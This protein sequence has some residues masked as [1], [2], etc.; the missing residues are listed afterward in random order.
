LRK[1]KH[2]LVLCFALV[3]G[4]ILAS[5]DTTCL[6]DEG[7]KYG[8]ESDYFTSIS[9]WTVE[10]IEKGVSF[11][12]IE[13]TIF[14]DWTTTDTGWYKITVRE[15]NVFQ[16]S[17]T[18]TISCEGNLV[19]DSVYLVG[20][21]DMR[22]EP[23]VDIEI[24]FGDS[25]S[26]SSNYVYNSYLWHNGQSSQS[27]TEYSDGWVSLEVADKYG[28][29][30]SDSSY[31]TVHDLPQVNLGNDTILCENDILYY[32]FSSEGVY[33]DW[34][35][36]SEH[37][38]S[39]PYIEIDEGF[40]FLYNNDTLS[41]T[42]ENTYG[43]LSSD[44]VIYIPCQNVL[45]KIP[46]VI[47]PNGDGSNDYWVIDRLEK[48]PYNYPELVIEI[49]DRWGKLVW[50][51]DPGYVGNEFMGNDLKGRELPS[52]SYFYVINLKNGGEPITGHLTILR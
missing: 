23:D 31:L 49:F 28:C 4:N 41:L 48:Y 29:K 30:W 5:V 26:Y 18:D 15:Y 36:G 2:I 44:T 39:S 24:C 21:S 22:I 16:T 12:Q 47:T 52:D 10:G 40:I 50:I 34:Y 17:G 38:S 25:V 3:S 27:I 14:V 37:I 46:T 51:S 43:C 32:D 1:F 45:G 6:Y 33:F 19:T 13:D 8:V 11:N 35:A 7:V 42:V 9:V 20:P